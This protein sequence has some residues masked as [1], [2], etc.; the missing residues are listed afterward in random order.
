MGSNLVDL[1]GVC[2]CEDGVSSTGGSM[3]RLAMV[4]DSVAADEL[5]AGEDFE[6]DI[7]RARSK[8]VR[9][10]SPVSNHYCLPISLNVKY[11]P[12]SPA[13]RAC[14]SFRPCRISSSTLRIRSS[15]SL[16]RRS[17][18]LAIRARNWSTDSAS[19]AA[20]LIMGD[21]AAG[22]KK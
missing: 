8:R 15:S 10:V 5:G 16:S 20:V 12:D 7:E 19:S 21:F 3:G 4:L 13:L 17:F 22:C 11:A 9:L 18:K 1:V 14:R 2:V 6:G